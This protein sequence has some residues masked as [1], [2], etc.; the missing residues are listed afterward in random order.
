MCDAENK[1]AE[2]REEVSQLQK[3]LSAYQ[4]SIN[5]RDPGE[6]LIE[7]PVI[8][9]ERMKHSSECFTVCAGCVCV[10]RLLDYIET[11]KRTD[12][13]KIAYKSWKHGGEY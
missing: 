7:V 10:K 9:L 6:R 4:G 1:A 8:E 3:E 13:G 2:L 12:D 5:L 11:P